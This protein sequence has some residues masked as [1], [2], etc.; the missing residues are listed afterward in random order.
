MRQLSDEPER[1]ALQKAV[2]RTFWHLDNTSFYK[3]FFPLHRFSPTSEE[4][5]KLKAP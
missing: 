5:D 1:N 2:Y 3:S 4:L